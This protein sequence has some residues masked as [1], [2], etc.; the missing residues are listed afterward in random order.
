MKWNTDVVQEHMFPKL[1]LKVKLNLVQL[2]GG[3]SALPITLPTARATPLDP[4]EWRQ[5]ISEALAADG[6]EKKQVREER[7]AVGWLVCV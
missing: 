1:R 7:L 3:I 2:N 4:T 5:Q 6:D